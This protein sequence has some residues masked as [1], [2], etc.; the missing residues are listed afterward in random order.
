MA[1]KKA[2][3]AAAA[4][5]R[6][7]DAPAADSQHPRDT[8]RDTVELENLKTLNRILVGKA[9]ERKKKLDEIS[10]ENQF[11]GDLQRGITSLVV[12]FRLAE[13]ADE[14][15]AAEGKARSTEEALARARYELKLL[16]EEKGAIKKALDESTKG[17]ESALVELEKM[18]RRAE[19]REAEVRKASEMLLSEL[20][21]RKVNIQSLEAEKAA[22][23]V[24]V[25]SLE[26]AL[27]NDS[28]KL[29]LVLKEKG[30]IEKVLKTAIL[31]KDACKREFEAMSLEL[32]TTTKKM[33]HFTEEYV[34]LKEMIVKIHQEYKEE[35]LNF[36][37]EMEA[38]SERLRGIECEIDQDKIVFEAS[39]CSLQSKV[40]EQE[41]K[42]LDQKLALADAALTLREANERLELVTEEHN[43]VKKA[44]YQAVS[45]RDLSQKKLAEEE[46]LKVMATRETES[47]RKEFD[48][49][50]KDNGKLQLA[51][52]NQKNE[53]E[54]EI[55]SLR[56][57]VKR[58]EKEKEAIQE[59]RTKQDAEIS[60]LQREVADL[61]SNVS[62]L[63]VANEEVKG[64]SLQIEEL[65][66][67][68]DNVHAE[69]QKAMASFE[70]F[71][72]ENERIKIE[73]D[74]LAR[75]NESLSKNLSSSMQ[76]IKEMDEKARAADER[77]SR[78]VA[79]LRSTSKIINGT[80]EGNANNVGREVVTEHESC[81]NIN[82]MAGE[83][84]TIKAVLECRALKIEELN[85]EIKVLHGSLAEATPKDGIWTW[86]YPTVST[87]VAAASIAYAV[88]R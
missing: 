63:N 40:L 50:V 66:K 84:E 36:I 58:V 27:R 88:K 75:E 51:I 55:D 4:T 22:L 70:S 60:D 85:S 23:L 72:A 13:M 17:R 68:R 7:S 81:E 56:V 12:S 30:E 83:L 33:N 32:E 80:E 57:A 79:M 59:T 29:Q 53:Y 5:A 21:Q 76:V 48:S 86:V 3:S 16:D 69:L 18:E 54:K 11:T 19:E 65:Q 37:K 1:K 28:D 62:D 38:L 45:E 52:D 44:M 49:I 6:P 25:T 39:I 87:V 15:K 26:E 20:E 67:E 61:M 35:K 24:K 46:D 31:E 41:K 73:S 77:L 74:A 43:D 64:L 47:L 14:K 9:N 82:D 71:V 10:A 78:V 34:A 8:A 42:N 2:A